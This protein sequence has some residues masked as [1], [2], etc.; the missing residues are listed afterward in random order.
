[1]WDPS[2]YPKG[3][4]FDE[5]APELHPDYY[6]LDWGHIILVPKK[7]SELRSFWAKYESAPK[8]QPPTLLIRASDND[9]GWAHHLKAKKV[10]V[11]DSNHTFDKEGNE[12]KLFSLTLNFFKK[13]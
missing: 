9:M 4:S 12:K 2:Y 10:I 6:T 7:Y 3:D 1:M 8:E 13:F 11:K 5:A